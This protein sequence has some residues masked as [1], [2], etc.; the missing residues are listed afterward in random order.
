MTARLKCGKVLIYN[1]SEILL[2]DGRLCKAR[3]HPSC[4]TITK[5]YLAFF[6]EEGPFLLKKNI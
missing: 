2:S 5:T 6:A 1:F 4:K 3:V